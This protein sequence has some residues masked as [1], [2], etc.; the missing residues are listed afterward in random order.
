MPRTQTKKSR[1]PKYKMPINP[2]GVGT[3]V[4]EIRNVKVSTPAKVAISSMLESVTK[5][6][7]EECPN[8]V[9]TADDAA[10]A[11]TSDSF[12]KLFGKRADMTITVPPPRVVFKKARVRS[13]MRSAK[14]EFSLASS[15]SSTAV[16]SFQQTLESLLRTAFLNARIIDRRS[17]TLTANAFNAAL[18]ISKSPLANNNLKDELYSELSN[19]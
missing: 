11:L 15:L 16:L 6:I 17:K 7:L 18:C 13:L 19:R 14:D 1:K 4:K 2:T 10:K 12:R 5:L 3:W 8:K 9:V